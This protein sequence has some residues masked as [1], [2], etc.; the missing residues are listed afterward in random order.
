MTEKSKWQQYK[1]KLGG[2]RPW[3]ILNPNI[4]KVSDEIQK[5]RF[6]ICQGCDRFIK[7]T[8]QCKECGCVMS[9]KTQLPAANCPLNKWHS[10]V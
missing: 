7:L 8:S 2:T 9:L 6:D 1:E 10:V 5:S 4:E 3:D